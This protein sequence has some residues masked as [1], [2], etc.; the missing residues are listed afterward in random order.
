MEWFKSI[1]RFAGLISDN[2]K[3]FRL[4]KLFPPIHQKTSTTMK[5]K[6]LLVLSAVAV[7]MAGCGP[8]KQ[9]GSTMQESAKVTTRWKSTP[10]SIVEPKGLIIEQT[11]DKVEASFF[12]LKEGDGFVVESKISQGKYFPEKKEIVL[13]PAQMGPDR[14]DQ[15]IA[16]DGGRVVVSFTPEAPS[17]KAK[18]VG[19]GPPPGEIEFVRVKE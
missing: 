5:K 13:P 1:F 9:S 8:S 17:L 10:E 3:S 18:W 12:H 7:L 14:I 4:D 19:Q 16:M 2:K 11:G 15:L 6:S